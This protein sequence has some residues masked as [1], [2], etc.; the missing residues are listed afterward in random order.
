MTSAI[1]QMIATMVSSAIK[2][3][4]PG[5]AFFHALRYRVCN[6]RI[7]FEND[8]AFRP[9]PRGD[10]PIDDEPRDCEARDDD[11]RADLARPADCTLEPARR[12]EPRPVDDFTARPDFG[13]PED[14]EASAFAAA[15]VVLPN[16]VDTPGFTVFADAVN[17]VDSDDSVDPVKSVFPAGSAVPVDSAGSIA[18]V[19]SAGSAIVLE[20]SDDAACGTFVPTLDSFLLGIGS[21]A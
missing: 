4:L 20:T 6:C 12:P 15:F 5:F 11:P 14:V 10:A 21:S 3:R 7:A 8:E 16:V 19:V 13:L 18:S 2:H 9:P 17:S 1:A